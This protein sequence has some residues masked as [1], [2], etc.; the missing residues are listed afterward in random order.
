MGYSDY[1]YSI[2]KNSEFNLNFSSIDINERLK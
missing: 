1:G 2:K